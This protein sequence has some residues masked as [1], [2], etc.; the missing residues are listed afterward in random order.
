M[1][2]KVKRAQRWWVQHTRRTYDSLLPAATTYDIAAAR[3][4]GSSAG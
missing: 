4:A 3:S 1:L 2:L